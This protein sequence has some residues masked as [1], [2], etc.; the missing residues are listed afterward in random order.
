MSCS[1]ISAVF[2]GG[3]KTSDIAKIKKYI[4]ISYDLVLFISL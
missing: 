3:K 1:F 2:S 4:L